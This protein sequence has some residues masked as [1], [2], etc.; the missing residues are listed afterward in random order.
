MHEHGGSNVVALLAIEELL[1]L[2][3]DAWITL[4]VLAYVLGMLVFTRIAADMVLVSA[5]VVLLLTGV[6]STSQAFAGFSNEGM[7]TVAAL[8]VVVA[9]LE[10]TGATAIVVQRL[11]GR[12][13]SV[14][15]ALVRLMFPVAGVSTLLNNTP[16]V[17]MFMPA[18]SDWA[19]Q[20]RISVSKLMMPL[21]YAAVLGG[22]CTL[23]GTSTNLVVNGLLIQSGRP[24]MK[25]FDVTWVGVPCA[26]LGIAFILLMHRFL[27]PDRTP[28][29]SRSADPREYTIEMIVQPGSPIVGQTL[30]AAG[31]RHLPQL[32]VMEIERRGRI[33]PAVSSQEKLEAEDRLVFVGVIESMLDLQKVRGLAPATNQVFKLEAPRSSRTLIEAVVS[34]RCP[35]VGQSIR[36]GRF[37]S[38]YNAAVIAVAR[39][40]ERVN[41]KIGDIVLR[42]GDT[43]LLEAHPSFV[44]Q[45]R[46]SRDF[47]L[48]SRVEN[49]TPPRHERAWIAL[50]ILAGM[51]LAA[52]LEWTSMLN[53]ALIAGGL[54]LL[55]RCCTGQLARRAVDW[56]TLIAIAAS[57]A[58]GS[59]VESSGLARL[60]AEGLI[61][62]AGGSPWAT[63]IVIYGITL[64]LT[65]L[66]TNNAAAVLTFPIG[67]QAAAN[68]GVD[69]QPFVIAV[70]VAA[71]L[72]FATPLGY[73]THLMVY[74][75]GG[76]HFTDFLRLGIPLDILCWIVAGAVI[77]IA[78][79]F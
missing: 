77:P 19:R 24:G 46:N 25:F 50:A 30:E 54:M 79:G 20:N 58:L 32:Y 21:S 70:T 4:A 41:M 11:L 60:F 22:V 55:T 16:V 8:F 35:L 33:L 12:P 63:V 17:A 9:G 14:L 71:S 2:R 52:S 69:Y 73:Q 75:P 65:E 49:S 62:L 44:D 51:V 37:R 13:R 36:D 26:L 72:G 3:T 61:G 7:L 56:Q 27:L 74:G 42:P 59:A 57:F 68:L 67:I 78:F 10:A 76:Y 40:G 39:S 47:Y 45:Q 6:L 34:D 15:G 1:G 18:V 64:V 23:I 53:A 28:A 31:L 29:I 43:L 48:V 66:I 5:V 38:V